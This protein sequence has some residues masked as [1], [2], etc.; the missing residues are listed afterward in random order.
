MFEVLLWLSVCIF[1][2]DPDVECGAIPLEFRFV[3]L[4]ISALLAFINV[5]WLVR[6]A[7]MHFVD[8]KVLLSW[9]CGRRAFIGL[10]RQAIKLESQL[11]SELISAGM[12]N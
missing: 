1:R 3:F 6:W 8:G 10:K 7:W 9:L 12:D 4:I 5:N 11:R 2:Q